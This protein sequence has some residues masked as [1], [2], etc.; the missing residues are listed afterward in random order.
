MMVEPVTRHAIE[1]VFGDFHERNLAEEEREICEGISHDG[2][3]AVISFT[4][5]KPVGAV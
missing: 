1:S 4:A 5:W 2:M 3:S